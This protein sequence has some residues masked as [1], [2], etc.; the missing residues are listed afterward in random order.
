V[1]APTNTD[2]ILADAW[3][4]TEPI[5]IHSIAAAPTITSY[6]PLPSNAE[7]NKQPVADKDVVEGGRVGFKCD[8]QLPKASRELDP[9]PSPSRIKSVTQIIS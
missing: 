5:I 8:V 3:I 1:N 9:T 6:Q 2:I 7:Q 4:Q